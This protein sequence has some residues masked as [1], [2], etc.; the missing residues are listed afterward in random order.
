MSQ[1]KTYDGVKDPLDHLE[2]FKTLILVKSGRRDHVQSLPYY[3]EGTRKDLVQQ[4]D[5]QLH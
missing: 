2:S 3:V 1:V 4:I 5:A